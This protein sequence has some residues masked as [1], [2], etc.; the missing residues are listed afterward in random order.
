MSNVEIE[1]DRWRLEYDLHF[2]WN[3]TLC[4]ERQL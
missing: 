1:N 4:E 2:D 3:N